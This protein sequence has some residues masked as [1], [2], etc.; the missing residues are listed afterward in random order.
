MSDKPAVHQR[1]GDISAKQPGGT[2]PPFFRSVPAY[3]ALR[4]H[5]IFLRIMTERLASEEISQLQYVAI[6]VLDEFPG[7]DQRT[8]GAHIGADRTTVGHVVDQL[9]AL[10]LVDRQINRQDRRARVL[11][12]TRRGAQLRKRL[13]PTL[14]SAQEAA[15][16]PLLPDERE[17]LMDLLVRVIDA[18]PVGP[19]SRSNAREDGRPINGRSRKSGIV[20]VRPQGR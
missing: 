19:R 17:Q 4:F 1:G 2:V 3:V 13:R 7:I 18:Y 5:H 14:R 12:V 9:E 20:G 11:R 15:L 8:L 6:A 16:E 10:G